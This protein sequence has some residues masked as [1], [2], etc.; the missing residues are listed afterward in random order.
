MAL[1][2][3][4]PALIVLLELS[5]AFTILLKLIVAL[6]DLARNKIGSDRS[7][8]VSLALID[9]AVSKPGSD[10]SF[11]QSAKHRLALL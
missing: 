2:D 11:K 8:R 3:E 7:S 10:Y 6:I 9:S 1:E 5:V 4:D